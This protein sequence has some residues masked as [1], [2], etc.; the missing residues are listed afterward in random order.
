MYN[1]CDEV[2]LLPLKV[3]CADIKVD[4]NGADFQTQEDNFIFY[5]SE[6]LV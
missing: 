5:L 4:A 6:A 2:A 1:T 3:L